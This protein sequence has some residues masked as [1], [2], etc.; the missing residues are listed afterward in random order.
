ML[1]D[2]RPQI[3]WRVAK[4]I[5]EHAVLEAS[6]WRR[7]T[8]KVETGINC[9][10]AFAGIG[11]GGPMAGPQKEGS[12]TIGAK[13]D[14]RTSIFRAQIDNRGKVSCLLE[15]TIAPPIQIVFSGEIDHKQVCSYLLRT[16]IEQR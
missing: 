11:P 16:F 14:F 5:P 4:I 1:D 13:Y 8:D 3:G 2:T 15:K 7:L 6:Y 10:L 12:V 9:N